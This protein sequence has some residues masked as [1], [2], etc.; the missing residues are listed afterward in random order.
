MQI[1]PHAR[2]VITALSALL[3]TRAAAH[4]GGAGGPEGACDLHWSDQFIGNGIA[5]SATELY[6]YN[7][8]SG[9]ALYV[10][11]DFTSADG[12][13]STSDIARWNGSQWSNVGAG[14]SSEVNGLIAY[15]FG[16]GT[17]LIAAG[18]HNMFG[19]DQI[20]Q[21]NGTQWQPVP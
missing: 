6:V 8:G 13:P 19:D 3:A 12:L 16:S 15:D 7:D 1:S 21:W 11:G 2:F 14:F 10:G 18:F 17:R 5:G 4:A 9:D 20:A